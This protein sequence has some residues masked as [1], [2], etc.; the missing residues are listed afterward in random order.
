MQLFYIGVPEQNVGA[1]KIFTALLFC[2][3]VSIFIAFYDL[4]NVNNFFFKNEVQNEVSAKLENVSYS[5]QL[6]YNHIK[7]F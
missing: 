1:T 2:E 3:N 4:H 6:Y 5:K 7:Y